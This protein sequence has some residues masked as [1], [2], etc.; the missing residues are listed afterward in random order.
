MQY[1]IEFFN[2]LLALIFT[3]YCMRQIPWFIFIDL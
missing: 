3:D 2:G 1:E